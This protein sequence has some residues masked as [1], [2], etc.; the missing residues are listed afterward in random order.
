MRTKRPPT[1][2]LFEPFKVFFALLIVVLFF[3]APVTS[4]V[5]EEADQE[6]TA[7]QEFFPVLDPFA[8]SADACPWACIKC[9]EWDPDAW[10]KTCLT[11]ECTDASGNCG[12]DGGGGGGGP[13]Y[14]PPTISHVLNCSNTGSNGWCIGTLSLDL[15]ASDP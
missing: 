13:S 15:T 7:L 5:N 9:T 10:P 8:S 6:Q 3:F 14:Q 2:K 1:F 11:Y 12:E 4:P